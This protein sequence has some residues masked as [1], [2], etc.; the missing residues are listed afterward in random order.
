MSL[1]S[2]Q[3]LFKVIIITLFLNSNCYALQ[4]S[5]AE[6]KEI[7]SFWT[8]LRK[9]ISCLI[10]TSPMSEEVQELPS[11]PSVFFSESEIEALPTEILHKICFELSPLMILSLSLTSKNLKSKIDDRFWKDYLKMNKWEIWDDS[12]PHMKTVFAH[13]FFRNGKTEKAAQLNHPRAIKILENR[14]KIRE[15]KYEQYRRMRADR[16]K[17]YY[18]IYRNTYPSFILRSRGFLRPPFY[19]EIEERY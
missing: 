15:E 4:G 11:S 8:S 12:L 16:N 13:V 14:E 7:F 18:G 17:E 5:E 3:I 1:K 9:C 6:K 10:C 2:S 19:N